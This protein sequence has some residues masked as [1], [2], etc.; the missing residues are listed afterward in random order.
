M[1]GQS[2]ETG[3]QPHERWKSAQE[4]GSSNKL[5]TKT[6]DLNG[7][8]VAGRQPA[9]LIIMCSGCRRQKGNNREK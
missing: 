3:V 4:R 8:D 5:K 7:D 1:L 9:V 6:H 2:V